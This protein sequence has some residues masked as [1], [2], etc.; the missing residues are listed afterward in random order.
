MAR[1]SSGQV[2]ACGHS[3][4]GAIPGSGFVGGSAN[5]AASWMSVWGSGAT[6]SWACE[7]N[8]FIK[9]GTTLYCTGNNNG[10]ALGIGSTT[11]Q[12]N[13]TTTLTNV[14]V[15]SVDSGHKWSAVV[16]A[17]GTCKGTQSSFINGKF[18]L[19][20]TLTWTTITSAV[21]FKRANYGLIS[22]RSNGSVYCSGYENS[23]QFGSAS[24]T[25][26]YS[27][28]SIP[29]TVTGI[30]GSSGTTVAFNDTSIFVAGNNPLGSLGVGST[31]ATSHTQSNLA[32]SAGFSTYETSGSI[33][34]LAAI[35]LTSIGT[36]NSIAVVE[37][38]PTGTDVKYALSFDGK[39]TWNVP[40]GVITDIATQGVDATTLATYN[41][42]GFT[43]TT[44]DVG[45]YLS[46]TDTS[47]SPT[48]DQITVGMTLNGHYTQI[49]VD[50]DKLESIESG[51]HVVTITNGDA[52]SNTYKI[53]IQ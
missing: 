34:S 47:V 42:T 23:H 43:G 44:L 25:N 27:Y 7:G 3:W 40:S 17:D 28:A 2:Y 51:T 9:S 5:G 14:D 52:V 46:T 35:D 53:S 4:A 12:Y 15:V 26:S 11:H 1:N 24:S 29:I 8:S 30:A 41:F 38:K 22:L 50:G 20:T 36:I 33:E 49:V 18:G 39:T 21:K 32:L 10:G 19:G 13:W 6:G 16:F 45:M 48:V 37:S 31:A